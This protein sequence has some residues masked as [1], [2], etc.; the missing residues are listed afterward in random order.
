MGEVL[1]LGMTHFPPL[2]GGPAGMTRGLEFFLSDPGIPDDKKDPASWPEDMRTDFAD[3]RG[4]AAAHRHRDRLTAGCARIRQALDE[5]QPDAV[6]VWGD[7][8]YENYREELVPAFSVLAFDQLTI[9]PF[10]PRPGRTFQ[11]NIWGL[12]Q[13]TEMELTGNKKIAKYVVT[14]LLER[15]FDPAYGYRLIHDEV[16]PHA[17][18]NTRLFLDPDLSGFP[19]PMIPFSINCYGRHVIN[20]KGGMVHWDVETGPEDADPPSPSPA[21]CFQLGA[22]T[23][24]ALKDSDFRIAVIASSSWSHA[25]LVDKNWRLWPDLDADQ[26]FYRALLDRDY[27]TWGKASLAEIEESGQ[28]EMLNWFCL[29]GLVDALGLAAQWTDF[30]P[31]LLFNSNKCFAVF[32]EP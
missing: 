2:L 20:R 16:F 3:D 23:G 21:R 19:H 26:R 5:F 13:E 6:I 14:S 8:Q 25:F 18:A 17:F 10:Q 24:A 29:V 32:A 15:G 31:G 12:G 30:V 4:L 11:P 9:R 28:Q 1:A 27:A 22:A 7:D